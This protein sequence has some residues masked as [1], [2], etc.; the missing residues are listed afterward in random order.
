M[1]IIK[2]ANPQRPKRVNNLEFF[3]KTLSTEKKYEGLIVNVRLDTVELDDG[4]KALREIV[5]HSGGVA[6]VAMEE[7]GSVYVVRQFR[8]PYNRVMTEIPAGKKNENEAPLDCGIRE[9]KEETGI[10]ADEYIYL[11]SVYPSPGYVEE[12]IFLYLALGLHHGDSRPDEGEF[13]KVEKRHISALVSDIME[14]KIYDAKTVIGLLKAEKYYK[15][16]ING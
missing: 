8:K 5:E 7:D 13:L 2:K 15:E 3:E 4:S 1:S 9:L 10:T 16:K 12:E 11:G 6:V 14:N